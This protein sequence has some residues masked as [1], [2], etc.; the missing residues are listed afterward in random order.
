MSVRQLNRIAIDNVQQVCWLS[1]IVSRFQHNHICYWLLF[2]RCCSFGVQISNA[3]NT[4][5]ALTFITS[6]WGRGRRRS[7]RRRRRSGGEGEEEMGEEEERRR[8][9]KNMLQV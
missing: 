3:L 1:C 4:C 6:D 5:T 9:R 7:R 8:R 2:Q